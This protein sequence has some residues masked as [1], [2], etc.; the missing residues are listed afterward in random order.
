MAL[1]Y[2]GTGGL[3]TRLGALVYMMD[4]VRAHQNNLKTLLANVQ[5]EYSS[6]DA[7]MIDVL[8]GGIEGRI[9]EAGNVLNDVRAAAERTILE[10]CYVEAIDASTPARSANNAHPTACRTRC[11]PTEP[12]YTAST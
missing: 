1:T 8:S 3:F 4:Q 5:A 9:A 6:T 12:K 10:M 7:W 2:T 11:M